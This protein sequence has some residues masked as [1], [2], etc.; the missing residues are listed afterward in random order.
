MF[1][2]TQKY[3]EEGN[4]ET[5]SVRLLV[6][7]A[8]KNLLFIVCGA[9][10]AHGMGNFISEAHPPTPADINIYPLKYP[11]CGLRKCSVTCRFITELQRLL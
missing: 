4:K 10:P 7:K 1:K 3:K 8:G 9:A 5:G 11:Q 2:T 6:P